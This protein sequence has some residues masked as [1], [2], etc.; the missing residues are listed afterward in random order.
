[1]GTGS[2]DASAEDRGARRL[3]RHWVSPNQPHFPT[4]SVL[5]GV[6]APTEEGGGPLPP[7]CRGCL[8]PQRSGSCNEGL[9]AFLWPVL[10]GIGGGRG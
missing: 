7:A 6:Q 3:G 9:R 10:Q 5:I 1:M 8:D 4:A 2:G